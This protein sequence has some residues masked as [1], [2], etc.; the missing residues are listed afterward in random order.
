MLSGAESDRG[1][2]RAPDATSSKT[3]HVFP[4]GTGTRIQVCNIYV[5]THRSMQAN[6]QS[7]HTNTNSADALIF[8]PSLAVQDETLLVGMYTYICIVGCSSSC[9]PALKL[10][11]PL[12]VIS[13]LC[14]ISNVRRQKHQYLGYVAL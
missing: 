3:V 10:Y 9:S 12:T 7:T 4:V 11:F 2:L 13:L 14:L 5:Y 8:R 6:T 1:E